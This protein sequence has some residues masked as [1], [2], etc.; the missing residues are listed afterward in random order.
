VLLAAYQ[1]KNQAKQQ[2]AAINAGGPPPEEIEANAMP[3]DSDEETELVMAAIARHVPQPL[4]RPI[5]I[6]VR[7]KAQYIRMRELMQSAL[8]PAGQPLFNSSGGVG[9]LL[10]GSISQSPAPTSGGQKTL[11]QPPPP[12]Q[13]KALNVSS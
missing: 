11:Q 6:P 10:G 1:K 3:V 4:E 13:R 12:A 7:R 2:K 8:R 9:G 5:M